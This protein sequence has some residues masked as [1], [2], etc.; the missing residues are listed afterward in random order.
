VRASS[1]A[2]F[3]KQ[4]PIADR[5]P[6]QHPAGLRLLVP[7]WPQGRWGQRARASVLAGSFAVSLGMGLWSWG[8]WAGWG[9]WAFAFASHVTS[10]LDAMRQTSFPVY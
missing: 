7:G 5:R 4:L 3:A 8:T 1:E 6:F 2:R 10:V 9:F